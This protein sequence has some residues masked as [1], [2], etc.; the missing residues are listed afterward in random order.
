MRCSNFS[1]TPNIMV[2]VVRMPSWCAVRCTLS[3][4]SVRHFR[5]AMRWRTSSSRISAPPPGM[6]SSPASRRRLIVSSMLSP[7]TSAKWMIS[8]A[9]KQ[10]RWTLGKRCFMP[11]QLEIRMQ[12]AL[13]Q[14]ARAADFHRLADL[15]VDGLKIQHVSLG[16]SGAFHGCVKSAESA[17]FSAEVRVIN[18]AVNDVSDHAFGVQLAP[19]RVC[20]HAQPDQVVRVEVVKCLLFC[21]GHDSHILVDSGCRQ[22]RAVKK[23]DHLVSGASGHLSAWKYS[24]DGIHWP[25]G[26]DKAIR[27]DFYYLVQFSM[28]L[29]KLRGVGL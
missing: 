16:A 23:S 12:P 5:R 11:L 13:H 8:E 7:L 6:E 20:L 9:E 25:G 29:Q 22:K 24:I 10:C 27:L 28:R 3:Q 26:C 15:S 4:S 2:A 21:Q 18:V 17:V 14:H 1:P 19:E